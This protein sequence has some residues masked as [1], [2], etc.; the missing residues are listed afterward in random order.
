M[1]YVT[2]NPQCWGFFRTH[3][4]RVTANPVYFWRSQELTLPLLFNHY[5]YEGRENSGV[6]TWSKNRESY[7]S[8]SLSKRQTQREPPH[9]GGFCMP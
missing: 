5:P 6:D 8:P 4:L 1:E 3:D 9:R 2:E 7:S